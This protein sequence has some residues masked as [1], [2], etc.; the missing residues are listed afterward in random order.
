MLIRKAAE[1]KERGALS[2]AGKKDLFEPFAEE[3]VTIADLDVEGEQD[4]EEEDQTT[5]APSW[6]QGGR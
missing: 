3:V 4:A 2:S 1:K 5:D 6:M